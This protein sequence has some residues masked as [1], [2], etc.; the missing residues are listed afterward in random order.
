ML[1]TLSQSCSPEYVPY[2]VP[3]NIT[4]DLQDATVGVDQQVVTHSRDCFFTGKCC[5]AVMYMPMVPSKCSAS[6]QC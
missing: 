1:H 4:A 5:C 6:V 3:S 2:C